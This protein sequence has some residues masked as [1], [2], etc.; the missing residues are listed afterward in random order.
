[1]PAPRRE[2]K[3]ETVPAPPRSIARLIAVVLLMQVAMA[4]AHCLAMAATPAG[5]PTVLCSP[6][7]VERI[8][9]VD[10]GGHALPETAAGAEVCVVCSG[11][12]QAA[13]P[14]PPAIP[15]FAWTGGARAW[16]VAG[17]ETLPPPARAP[18]FAPRAPPA[19]A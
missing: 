17:A 5:L 2:A 15:A 7:G 1:M 19:F 6:A 4:P 3:P 12:A 9:M 16:H 10:A 8:I 11:L 18:P 14:A 13:L